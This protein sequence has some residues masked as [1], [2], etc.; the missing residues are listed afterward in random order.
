MVSTARFTTEVGLSVCLFP[1]LDD[2]WFS[3]WNHDFSMKSHKNPTSSEKIPGLFMVKVP[4]FIA[5]RDPKHTLPGIGHRLWRRDTTAL[6]L[7][8][9]A[10]SRLQPEQGRGAYRSTNGP[11]YN[12]ATTEIRYITHVKRTNMVSILS[13][14]NGIFHLTWKHIRIV[15]IHIYTHTAHV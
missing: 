11:T 4:M 8:L 1:Y 14:Y 12:W 5:H 13:N 6:S 15:C 3:R 9:G 7:F 10:L 2:S